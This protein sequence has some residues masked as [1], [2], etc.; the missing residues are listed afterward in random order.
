[1]G[2]EVFL[3]VDILS[4]DN[5]DTIELLWAPVTPGLPSDSGLRSTSNP[6]VGEYKGWIGLSPPTA[7]PSTMG[8]KANEYSF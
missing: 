5:F 2:S 1:M 8:N 4:G 3:R 7:Y 6:D